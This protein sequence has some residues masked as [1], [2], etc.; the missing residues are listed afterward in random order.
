MKKFLI[1]L[2]IFASPLVADEFE[3]MPTIENVEDLGKLYENKMEI[4]YKECRK[5]RKEGDVEGY[6]Y[7]MGRAEAYSD[8]H[9]WTLMVGKAIPQ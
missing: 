9:F 5:C 2:S 8:A 1:A 3:Y 4:Y 6:F 7:N